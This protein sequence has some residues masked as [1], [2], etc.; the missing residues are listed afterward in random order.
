MKNVKNI[1]AFITFF[2][3]FV[4][5]TG[6]VSA[7]NWTVSPGGNI[8][9]VIN[10]ASSGDIITVNDNNG[11]AYTYT[12]NFTISKK[13]TLKAKTGASVTLK[14]LNSSTHV[15][16]INSGANGTVIQG[17]T[18]MGSTDS[19]AIYLNSVSKC[20]ISGNTLI[21]N[22]YGFYIYKGQ[23]NSIYGNTIINSSYSG[24]SLSIS[25]NNTIQNNN[26]TGNARGIRLAYSGTD[27]GSNYNNILNNIISDNGYGIGLLYSSNNVINGNTITGSDSYGIYVGTPLSSNNTVIQS[28]TI[29][30]NEY[31][32]YVDNSTATI[33]FNRIFNNSLYG[34]YKV[35]NGIVNATNN[36]WG[37]NST[38]SVSLTSPSDIC[39]AQATV[40][41]DPWL[42]LNISVS[43][44]T[45]NNNST[46][47]ADLTHNSAGADTSS[48][49]HIPDNIPINFATNLGTI[50]NPV[51][52]KN[53]KASAT[54]NRGTATSGTATITTTLDGQTLQNNITIDTIVPI[55][56]ASL[57]S[58][59][60]TTYQNVT[61]TATDNFDSNPTIYYTLNGTT[62]TTSSTRYTGPINIYKNSTTLKFMAVDAAGNQAPVQ[63]MTYI[64]D[65]PII[66][67]NTSKVYSTIQGALDDSLTSNG[68]TI[69]LKNGTYNEDV[70][71]NKKVIV[72]SVPGSNATVQ[73]FTVNSGGSGSTIQ[74]LTVTNG[75]SLNSATNCLIKGNIITNG[76]TLSGGNNNIIS[77]NT[78]SGSE[79]GISISSSSYNT[80]SNNTLSNNDIGIDLSGSNNNITGNEITHNQWCGIEGFYTSTNGNLIT[81]NDISNNHGYGIYLLDASITINFNRIV[82]NPYGEL[83]NDGGSSINANNNWWGSNNGP[84]ITIDGAGDIYN[85]GGYGQVI[86]DT[87]LV[88]NVTTNPTNLNNSSNSTLTIDLTHNNAGTNTSSQGHIPDN[89]PI[90][91]TT[92]LGTVTSPVSTKNG[93]ASAT[94]GHGIISSGTAAIITTLDGQSITNNVVI[95]LAAIDVNTGKL[96]S[97]IQD[98]INNA[99]ANDTIQVYNGTYMGNI[100]VNKTLTIMPVSGANVTIQILNNSKPLITIN[101]GVNVTIYNI[102]FIN[103][104]YNGEYEYCGVIYNEGN[105]TLKN[106]TFT[107]NNGS[108]WGGAIGN[109]GNLTITNCTFMGNT[110][111]NEGGGA[112]FNGGNLTVTGSTFTGNTAGAG[113]AIF[114]SGILT[115]ETCN[116]TNNNASSANNGGGAIFNDGYL[117]VTG[118]TF[119]GNTAGA[120]G[121]AIFNDDNVAYI[122]FNR[123]VENGNCSLD[124]I[125]LGVVD[126]NNNW[127]GSN[128]GPIISSNSSCDIKNNIGA[129]NCNYWLILSTISSDTIVTQG[130]SLS[131]PVYLTYNNQ[132]DDTSSSGYILDETPITF[133]TNMGTINS[134]VYTTKGATFSTLNFN[135]T[136]GNVTVSLDNQNISI[137]ILGIFNSIQSAINN[138]ALNGDIGIED[139]TYTENIALNKQLT[140][141]PVN[142]GKVTIQPLD[143]TI[144]VITVTGNKATIY[145]LNIKGATN[146]DGIYINSNNTYIIGNTLT[147]NKYGIYLSNTLNS[148]L[149]ENTIFNNSYTGIF[150]FNSNNITVYDNILNNTNYGIY[151]NN[152]NNITLYENN[153]LKNINDGIYLCNSSAKINFNRIYGNGKYGLENQGNGTIDATDNWWGSNA[154]PSSNIHINGGTVNST[155]WLVLNVNS[156]CDR[157]NSTGTNYNYIVT[158]DLTHNNNGTD[159]SSSGSIPD[160]TPINFTLGTVNATISTSRGKAQNT[161]NNTSAG[162][163]NISVALDNQTVTNSINVTSTTVLGV[164]NTRTGKWY[165]TIQSA[166]SCPYTLDGDTITLASGTYT[167]NVIVDK[168]VT[169]MPASGANVIVRAKYSSLPVFTVENDNSTIKGLNI[170]SGL[171]GID[172]ESVINCNITGN[173]ITNTSCGIY[174]DTSNSS[175][176]TGNTI[177]NNNYGIY[178]DNSKN[179]NI[180]GNTISRNNYGIHDNSKNN[181]TNNNITRNLIG[182]ECIGSN[183]TITG[184]NV[185]TNLI[186]VEYVDSNITITGNNVTGNLIGIEYIDS[187]G[188]LTGN[189]V[190]SNLIQDLLHVNTTGIVIVDTPYN[191][192][193]AALAT[194]LQ[195]YFDINVSQDQLAILAG[196]DETGTSMYGLVQAVH[197]EGLNAEGLELSVDQLEPGNIVYLTINGTGHYSVITNITNTTVYL[198][199]SEL[200]NI[201]MSLSDFTAAY[202]GYALVITNGTNTQNGTILTTEEME[203]I[204]GKG[205]VCPPYMSGNTQKIINV[206]KLL[207]IGE[208]VFWSITTAGIITGTAAANIAFPP[209]SVGDGVAFAGAVFSSFQAGRAFGEAWNEP[210]YINY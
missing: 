45:T 81:G 46:I 140:L 147:G 11:T 203:N 146:S 198:A 61:L 103:S 58:G 65:L 121:S 165:S 3:I 89:I 168:D 13:L 30:N 139:G 182:I 57:A 16:T 31:G 23:N 164:Y 21:G 15:I 204:K 104:N 109:N 134:T 108:E 22:E 107:G 191:C 151:I 6:A 172:I 50:T 92:T 194:V 153:I 122:N 113:G 105:L 150:V 87:W 138:T 167:E 208:V 93:K 190:T 20:N 83:E 180:T 145:G 84:V 39:I 171:C 75:I 199:D 62:P 41:Y 82:G 77:N 141:E 99:S 131:I 137:P 170:Q 186:G 206:D 29:T 179:N 95:H 111:N 47:T 201:N 187:N 197:D 202:S 116:F 86:C 68:D 100:I 181:L 177:S 66:D 71:V 192:G 14:T 26:L 40:T 200:G 59:T 12:G 114:N 2:A 128:S 36:W 48:Q 148:L 120:G 156:S 33:N 166:I 28:N 73:S 124:N 119:T 76:V 19:N 35:D 183:S 144:P 32:I 125:G 207:N 205:C 67:F 189:N 195:N 210:W 25:N 1:L 127:W 136:T 117:T 43:L 132:G 80:I 52:T 98:A 69:E 27:I 209:D 74:N 91:L 38:P 162:I 169:I 175:N 79:N 101:P 160:G 158:A 37:L 142:P 7:A 72:M 4:M 135:M 90:N 133:T 60:Y 55:V 24:I 5:F 126:A 173:T 102:I 110:A 143:P 34:I 112:I 10:N 49:G 56:N 88:L 163:T 64:I 188:T 161:L 94:F 8:Q 130:N 178:I 42:I 185:T 149:S 18:I 123:I 129:V 63:T 97:A 96:Y 193:P 106:C 53:G 70:T 115:V 118:S 157:S 85:F 154:N 184:N 159:T 17:F 174:V 155:T 44:P 9:S 51:N 152:S 176:I 78:I 196:T 54:F